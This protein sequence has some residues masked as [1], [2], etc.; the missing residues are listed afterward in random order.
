MLYEGE[1]KV[2]KL[3]DFINE[4]LAL[5]AA[6]NLT[7]NQWYRGHA[8]ED[9]ALI[10]KIQRGF[11]GNEDEELFR[12][13][14]V[15]T[16]AFQSKAGTLPIPKPRMDE[17][18]DWLTIM[19]HYNLPTRLL[20]WSRSPLVALYFAVSNEECR[21][22]DA[23]IWV[24]NPSKLNQSEKL[25]KPTI[26][27]DAEYPN[28]F[29]YNMSH[30]TIHRMIYTA[31]RRWELSGNLDAIT[32]DDRKFEHLFNAVKGKIAA[33][34]PVIADSRVYN[35]LAAF[36]VHNTKR[37][38]EDI[39]DDSMLKRVIIPHSAKET[40]LYELAVC[41]ITLEH[42]FPDFDHLAKSIPIL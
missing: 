28:A 3:S 27:D 37:K 19:Q 15:Y 20:D 1:T 24:L 9:W 6:D 36:T 5:K 16:N 18:A 38:L 29:V 4:I 42:I 21:N 13:E 23:C 31:F 35:Q 8:N 34:Y 14:R 41:G 2:K 12:L 40:L 30:R 7:D 33:C 26:I 17:Y 10:P 32:P 11:T 22:K 25:E 39:C